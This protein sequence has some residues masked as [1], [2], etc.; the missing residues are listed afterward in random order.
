VVSPTDP[1]VPNWIDTQGRTRGLLF[2]RWQGLPSALPNDLYPTGQVVPI[3]SVKDALPADTPSVTPAQRKAE[4]A[5]RK[6]DLAVRLRSSSNDG[7]AVIDGALHQLMAV[8]GDQPVL[9]IY[10]GSSLK[11]TGR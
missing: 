2:L 11:G 8:V 9:A 4:V 1:G 7:R 6:R 3:A 10:A 5:T